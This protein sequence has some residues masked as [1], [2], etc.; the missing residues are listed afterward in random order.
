MFGRY[1]PLT[2]FVGLWLLTA[3]ASAQPRPRGRAQPQIDPAAEF[4]AGVAA[5]DTGSFDVALAAFERSYGARQV[6]AVLYNIAATQRALERWGEAAASY[7]QYLAED[8]TIT[9]ERRAEVE[10]ILAEIARRDS[11]RLILHVTP[12]G[13]EI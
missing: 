4:A 9:P 7:R 1:F 2:L 12:E 8:L 5:Y 10:G 3:A 13:A 6:P 11:P